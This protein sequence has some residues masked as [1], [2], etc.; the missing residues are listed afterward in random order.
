MLTKLSFSDCKVGTAKHRS[1]VIWLL[2][3]DD[4]LAITKPL[5]ETAHKAASSILFARED[6][7][8]SRH[9]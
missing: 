6:G 7:Y 1:I 4:A 8:R 2:L 5:L 3:N 9:I